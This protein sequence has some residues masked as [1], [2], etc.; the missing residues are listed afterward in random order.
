MNRFQHGFMHR[1]GQQG[2]LVMSGTKKSVVD[3]F[4][5]HIGTLPVMQGRGGVGGRPRL[6]TIIHEATAIYQG[7]RPHYS[8]DAATHSGR[9][10]LHKGVIRV[11][12]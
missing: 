4:I 9:P 3:T 7:W 10:R 11:A 6:L 5:I 1:K 2:Q 8:P 12:F